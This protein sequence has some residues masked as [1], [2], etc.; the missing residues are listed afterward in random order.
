MYDVVIGYFIAIVG[1]FHPLL[2]A[3][4]TI[5]QGKVTTP[6]SEGTD[7]HNSSIGSYPDSDQ[8]EAISQRVRNK[9]EASRAINRYCQTICF[10]C[11]V[12]S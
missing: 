9:V 6:G 1:I 10:S 7:V 4:F 3:S 5:Y 2:W 8:A 11:M 12:N